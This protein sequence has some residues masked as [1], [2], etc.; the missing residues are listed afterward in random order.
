MSAA[1]SFT[2][3]EVDIEVDSVPSQRD[4]KLNSSQAH[5]HTAVAD[6]N[7]FTACPSTMSGTMIHPR[8]VSS[9]VTS[10]GRLQPLSVPISDL[11]THVIII[12]SSDD[13]NSN[14]SFPNTLSL[15]YYNCKLQWLLLV[16]VT[17]GPQISLV[18]ATRCYHKPSGRS[19]HHHPILESTT[20]SSRRHKLSY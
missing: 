1:D 3:T 19:F 2:V 5:L 12:P 10:P 20:L 9:H 17:R 8:A 13:E 4:C 15:Y 6:K 16:P 14:S 7:E 18:V 11:R